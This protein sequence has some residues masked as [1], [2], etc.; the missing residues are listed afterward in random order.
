VLRC[1]ILD[2]AGR[3]GVRQRIPPAREE[4]PSIACSSHEGDCPTMSAGSEIPGAG[5]R[6]V[7]VDSARMD[8]RWPRQVKEQ[9]SIAVR[10]PGPPAVASLN[11]R[12]L[13]FRS[14]GL[15]SRGQPLQNR[16]SGAVRLTSLGQGPYFPKLDS[17]FCWDGSDNDS[18]HKDSRVASELL[19]G[20]SDWKTKAGWDTNQGGCD[21]L[22]ADNDLILEFTSARPA[23]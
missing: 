7:A 15:F 22:P 14:E 18:F 17:S 10:I 20:S 1:P 6:V 11:P 16:A 23:T 13:F 5:K 2:P 9:E 19:M 12:A 8:A 21:A 4:R 3:V